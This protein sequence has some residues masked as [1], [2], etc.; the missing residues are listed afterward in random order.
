MFCLI[1]QVLRLLKMRC[2]LSKRSDWFRKKVRWH[3]F[4]FSTRPMN[5]SVVPAIFN[6]LSGFEI[7]AKTLSVALEVSLSIVVFAF[8]FRKNLRRKI[9]IALFLLTCRKRGRV[10]RSEN[11]F[12]FRVFF[13]LCWKWVKKVE[14]R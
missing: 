10:G 5:F 7:I 11:L 9:K 12:I 2:G 13:F 8:S 6:I 1:P 4:A 14:T 3:E